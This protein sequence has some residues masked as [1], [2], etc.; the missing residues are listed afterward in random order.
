MPHAAI[1]ASLPDISRWYAD[2]YTVYHKDIDFN[3][4]LRLSAL[5]L[6]LQETAW[7][8]ARAIGVDYRRPA[9]ASIIWV[10]SRMRIEMLGAP[11]RWMETVKLATSPTGIDRL[12]ALRDFLA[13]HS[14][15]R[16]FAR[17]ASA[18]IMIDA[19]SRRPV[20]PQSLLD[21]SNFHFETTVIPE[22]TEKLKENPDL[23]WDSPFCPSYADIDAHQHVNNVSYAQWCLDVPP[24]E[25]FREHS[26]TSFDIN[27]LAELGWGQ[28]VRIGHSGSV[29]IDLNPLESLESQVGLY[30]DFAVQK[31][32]DQENAAL[33]RVGWQ[34]RD[35]AKL[36]S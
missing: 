34:R 15:G 2:T 14:D 22:G 28:A 27:F 12:F 31:T 36:Q 3:E 21:E 13:M 30:Q 10:L 35:H 29:P 25:F 18:W 17:V 19:A 32:G 8:H 33:V 16:P 5:L 11:P 7:N 6:M 9:F 4:E 24:Q 26:L 23:T 20:R 1:I